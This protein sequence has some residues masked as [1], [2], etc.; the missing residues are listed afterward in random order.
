M[1]DD[2]ARIDSEIR[3]MDDENT[4]YRHEMRSEMQRLYIEMVELKGT[5]SPLL[6]LPGEVMLLKQAKAQAQAGA[7]V[8][9][10]LWKGV[11]AVG[12]VVLGVFL[13]GWISDGK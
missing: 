11:A 2:I 5:I 3:R 4:R 13:K 9:G 6:S 12:L 1:S 8:I 10:W 7:A